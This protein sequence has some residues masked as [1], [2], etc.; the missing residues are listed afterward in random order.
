MLNVFRPS[1]IYVLGR[2]FKKHISYF[3][4]KTDWRLYVKIKKDEGPQLENGVR[5]NLVSDFYLEKLTWPDFTA[6][7]YL[8]QDQD[9]TQLQLH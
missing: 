3:S 7:L 4:C 2:K 6:A 8:Y 5:L 1:V 9:G